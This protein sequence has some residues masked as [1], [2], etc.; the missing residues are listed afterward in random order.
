[1]LSFFV[2]PIDEHAVVGCRKDKIIGGMTA[3]HWKA[4]V[5]YAVN[6]SWYF[7]GRPFSMEDFDL[8]DATSPRNDAVLVFVAEY[9]RFYPKP[10]L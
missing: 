9:R 1:M 10:A 8:V 5:S 6:Q 4:T 2:F 3:V 7:G